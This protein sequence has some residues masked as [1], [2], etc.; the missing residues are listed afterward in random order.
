[1]TLA[2]T[3]SHLS[4]IAALQEM[5][6]SALPRYGFP[7]NV[8]VALL[9][10]SE[11]TVFR[12]DN[13]NTGWRAVM[14]VH[15]A[16]Y[17]TPNAIQSELDWMTAL[18]DAGIAT[19]QPLR[20][21]DGESLIQ[22]ETAAAGKRMIATF[23]WVEGDF[24]DEGNLPPSLQKLGELSARMHRQSRQWQRPSYFERHTWSLDDTVGENGRWGRWRDAPWL[25]REQVNVLERARDLMSLRLA[26]FGMSPDKYGLI[27]A[28][29]RIANLL[30]KG[31]RTTIIDFDDCG[32]GWFLHD[33]ATALSFIEHRPDRRELMLRWA[34]GY[35]RHGALTQADIEEFPTF[36]MQRRLQLLA[37]MA[38]HS[39]TELAQS[40]GESWVAGTA[41]L[42]TDYLHQMG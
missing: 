35:S 37:W 16:N 26:S 19:P 40:L 17:Q 38:S 9:S 1:M 2:T 3:E 11:N 23:A 15:R 25:D 5:A 13:P 14:R 41:E 33:M 30:V 22:V 12:L 34:E 31:P 24:P 20:T 10:H 4:Y 7:S 36:L 42:A 6:R 18:N 27:H 39:E 29:L 21:L 28:D 8:Q 32:I